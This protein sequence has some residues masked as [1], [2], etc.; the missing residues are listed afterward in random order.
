MSKIVY[1]DIEYRFISIEAEY[2]AVRI[3]LCCIFSAQEKLVA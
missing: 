1:V 2:S 3:I